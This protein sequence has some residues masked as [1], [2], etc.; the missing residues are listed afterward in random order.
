MYAFHIFYST[1]IVN[2]PVL[3][4]QQEKKDQSVSHRTAIYTLTLEGIEIGSRVRVQ[5]AAGTAHIQSI[6]K[7]SD[8]LYMLTESLY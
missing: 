5:K 3:S 1:V 7:F 4:Y 2:R 8:S 6:I